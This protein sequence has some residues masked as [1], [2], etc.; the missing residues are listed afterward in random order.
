[1]R[2]PDLHRIAVSIGTRVYPDAKQAQ[3]T[4]YTGSQPGS[5]FL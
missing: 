3:V 5:S 4:S 1:M 2:G